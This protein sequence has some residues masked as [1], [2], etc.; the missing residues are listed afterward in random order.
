M[1][2][3][4]VSKLRNVL[5]VRKKRTNSAGFFKPIHF[6]YGSGLGSACLGDLL[7][8]TLCTIGIHYRCKPHHFPTKFIFL[9]RFIR[10]SSFQME[11]GGV[12]GQ[13]CPTIHLLYFP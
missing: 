5:G 2:N 6:Q 12:V 11:N 1:S 10:D 4:I 13:T 7:G 9:K 3:V 8:I